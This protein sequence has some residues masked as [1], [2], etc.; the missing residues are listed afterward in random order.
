MDKLYE[1]LTPEQRIEDRKLRT[2]QRLVDAAG[3]LIV[4]GSLSRPEAE[5]LAQNTRE[6]A[7]RIIP[8]QMELYELIYGARFRRWIETFTIGSP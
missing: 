2:L 4:T 8:D 7:Q 6:A 3:R 5:R 1:S